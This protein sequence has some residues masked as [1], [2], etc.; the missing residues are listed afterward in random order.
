[1]QPI[2]K[3]TG[4]ILATTPRVRSGG[5]C[6]WLVHVSNSGNITAAP[7]L[8]ITLGFFGSPS[9]SIFSK[10]L[11]AKVPAN[12]KGINIRLRFRFPS[13]FPAGV[14]NPLVTITEDQVTTYAVST[15]TVRVD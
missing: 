2:I 5:F 14:Y 1:A 13:G 3:L 8:T 11:N 7:P 12:R 6:V 10:V 4:S 15:A 9:P